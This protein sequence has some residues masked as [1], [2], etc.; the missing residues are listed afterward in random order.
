MDLLDLKAFLDDVVDSFAAV[1]DLE[2][3]IINTDPMLRISGTGRFRGRANEEDNWER[4]YTLQVMQ[5]GE[6]LAVRD[7]T[8][9]PFSVTDEPIY[10]SILLYP[11]IL[12]GSV[13]GVIVV[14]SFTARQQ[15]ILLEKE[16]SLLGYL[17]KT[18]DL[19][20]AKLEQERLLHLVRTR[21]AQ[22]S[23]VFEAVKGGMLLCSRDGEVLQINKR[24]RH[25]LC[26]D[27]DRAVYG[28]CLEE[29][30]AV[31]GQALRSQTVMEKELT[32][33]Q[34]GRRHHL[35]L[36]VRPVPDD[37]E[38]AL[39]IVNPFSAL[40]DT[41]I[42]H[43]TVSF[44]F[45][46]VTR[47]PQMLA[48]KEQI[49]TVSQNSSNILLLGESGTGKEVIARTI[50]ASGPRRSRPFVTV[51][52]AA[53]PETLLESEL[54]GYE[55]GAF[56]GAK[57]GG[58]IGKFMLADT[59]TLFLDEIGDMPLYLQAKVLRVLTDRQIDRIGSSH[60]VSVDVHIIAATNK[61][62]EQLIVRGEFREDLYY[63]LSVITLRIPPLRE[64]REDIPLLIDYFIEK[65][66]QKLDRNITGIEAGAQR[67]LQQYG[68]P[69][70]V[71]EL[72]NCI[73]YMMNFEHS[74]TLSFENIP[75]RIQ[76]GSRGAPGPSAPA[77]PDAE[78]RTLKEIVRDCELQVLTQMNARYN[79]C[80]TLKQIRKICS[81]LG[82]SVASYYRKMEGADPAQRRG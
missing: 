58:R 30:V 32:F 28:R 61:N 16:E 45:D 44:P 35:T 38:D 74:Q 22:L 3:T 5:S 31:V 82:I 9:R 63:R 15:K 67:F 8:S 12:G 54:F 46:L 73:E 60:L 18:A 43:D 29:I 52:C 77:A 2:L 33:R 79:G 42:Q 4:S 23:G 48:L 1:L 69:G 36:T 21:N 50:H 49:Q 62:L 17:E 11:I 56:T 68:W 53:I 41:I 13:E 70:N 26:V 75:Q 39:C 27:Q 6:P 80:S 51:N 64:R 57:R 65:Y 37:A 76:C 47:N 78:D 7:T 24:A 20:S 81:K 71:R 10:Y 25:L 34:G 59:G 14:A 66:N 40:Q 55:E 72:E 19:I